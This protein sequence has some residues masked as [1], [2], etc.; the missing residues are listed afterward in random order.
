MECKLPALILATGFAPFHPR[1][2]LDLR[3]KLSKAVDESSESFSKYIDTLLAGFKNTCNECPGN[4][5][6]M[7]MEPWL[8]CLYICDLRQVCF[9]PG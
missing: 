5:D 1:S 6:Y 3:G 8:F 7:G 2:S 9:K 4:S